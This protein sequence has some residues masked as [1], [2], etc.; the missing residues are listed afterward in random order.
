VLGLD[1][2]PLRQLALR[3]EQRLS[4]SDEGKLASVRRCGGRSCCDRWG[5]GSVGPQV[6]LL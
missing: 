4:W 3:E 5:H 1:V 2:V 6:R